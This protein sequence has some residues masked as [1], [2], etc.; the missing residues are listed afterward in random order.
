MGKEAGSKSA[1]VRIKL[2]FAL[3]GEWF[4]TITTAFVG[5]TVWFRLGNMQ[6][7]GLVTVAGLGLGLSFGFTS[8]MYNRARAYSEGSMQRRSL[9]AAEFGLRG[10]LTL[11]LAA[12]Y[13]GFVFYVLSDTGYAPTA[14]NRWP[15]RL[16]PSLATI[17]VVLLSIYAYTRFARAV[18]L[19][20]HSVLRT[21]N[22]SRFLRRL[23]RRQL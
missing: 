15:V 13:G 8:L 10:S 2:A 20:V 14:A 1:K 18:R 7:D 9:R 19:V 16:V 5:V 4:V 11:A 12:V 21:V 23:K 17:P 3:I 22:T 6:L